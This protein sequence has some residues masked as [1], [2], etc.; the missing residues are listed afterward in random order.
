M[1][2]RLFAS[3]AKWLGIEKV[4][5]KNQQALDLFKKEGVPLKSIQEIDFNESPA[6]LEV[7]FTKLE[8]EEMS[9]LIT[10][11]C[12]SEELIINPDTFK[13]CQKLL[14]ENGKILLSTEVDKATVEKFIN[15]GKFVLP[16]GFS[17]EIVDVPDNFE[18]TLII[19][20]KTQNKNP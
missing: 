17:Y 16:D 1:A 14:K 8:G 18:K 7:D 20:S 15:D 13:I 4:S 2:K 9:D 3:I 12:L 10:M 19:F 6:I 11:F 5:I